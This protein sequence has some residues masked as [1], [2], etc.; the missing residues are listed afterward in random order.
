MPSP[1]KKTPKKR[2]RPAKSLP[3]SS[4]KSPSPSKKSTASPLSSSSPE[5]PTK[6]PRGRP[7][8]NTTTI[9]ASLF[10]IG[11]P[12]PPPPPPPVNN[13]FYQKFVREYWERY[14]AGTASGPPPPPQPPSVN[15]LDTK[16]AAKRDGIETL[17]V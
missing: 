6:R 17:V 10:D 16:P 2:G 12:P 5:S 15:N 11:L 7:P 4:K 13:P 9:N 3:S 14:E 1:A 8:K